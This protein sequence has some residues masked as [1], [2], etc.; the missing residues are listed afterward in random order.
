MKKKCSSY[1][2]YYCVE[3]PERP[4]GS[5]GNKKAT[6]KFQELVK[7]FGWQVESTSFPA[8]DWKEE[9]AHLW[10]GNNQYQVFPSPFSLGCDLEGEL[11]IAG[12]MAELSTL[13]CEKKILFLHSDLTKEQLMPKNFVFYNPQH[14]QKIISTLEEKKPAA[15][16]CATGRN[17]SVAGGVY[18]FPLIEDGDFQIPSVFMTEEEGQRL[19]NDPGTN[20]HLIS[21]AQRIPSTADSITAR[22]GADYSRR[23]AISAHI[24]AKIG[25]PGAIDNATGVIVLLLV[26]ELLADYSGDQV[27]ELLPFN[28]EDYYA[29]PGQMIYLAENRDQWN[30]I[31]LNIN[32]DGA[33]YYSG[34]TSFSSFNLP[35]SF[36]E[37]I[38]QIINTRET[39]IEGIPWV[40]GDHSIFI[41]QG[42]P[43][44]AI[45]SQWFIENMDN[46]EIT[47]TPKDHPGIVDCEKISETAQVIAEIVQDANL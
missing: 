34:S 36:Q 18:P 44:L 26:A 31:K 12:N 15:I 29:V 38:D 24:D 13:D 30:E 47:H 37:K 3:I 27:I 14:H 11:I 22:K 6:D 10:G 41:Q 25:T 43:A 40:Q 23:I 39:I 45:S 42:V 33:G 19:L 46:Q 35:G 7:S 16:I 17:S 5:I 4:V 1:L 20:F 28:G 9:G 32:I 21:G 8:M 2:D